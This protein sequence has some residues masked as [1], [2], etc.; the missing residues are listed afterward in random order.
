[1]QMRRI[2]EHPL[3]RGEANFAV[4]MVLAYH[5][6]QEGRA[7]PSKPTIARE[8]RI[9][10][11]T[12]DSVVARLE[13]AGYFTVERGG[14]SKKT[15]SYMLHVERGRT[16]EM[17]RKG[18]KQGEEQGK[19]PPDS[20]GDS[21]NQ[22]APVHEDQSPR[23]L[24]GLEGKPPDKYG[25]NGAEPPDK[26]GVNGGPYIENSFSNSNEVSGGGGAHAHEVP[27]A[28]PPPPPPPTSPVTLALCEVCGLMLDTLTVRDRSEL[29]ELLPWLHEVA[30]ADDEARAIAVRQ[31]YAPGIWDK[32]K[33]PHLSQIKPNWKRME[34]IAANAKNSLEVTNGTNQSQRNGT[35]PAFETSAE[36]RARRQSNY[37][38]SLNERRAD[39]ERRK[40]E[41]GL[42]D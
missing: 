24:G 6:D 22:G 27:Q 9:S 16:V 32:P 25:V 41:A 5:A 34:M 15:N 4:L 26:Y 2:I 37:Y 14:G 19:E 18:K 8:A 7:W 30:G 13:R 33:P 28:N 29:K 40:R 20:W 1:M 3:L 17:P 31:R 11:S 38:D 10:E 23:Q 39:F 35:K 42:P 36:R 21:G 12:A